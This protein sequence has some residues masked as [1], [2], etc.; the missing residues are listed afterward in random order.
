MQQKEEFKRLMQGGGPKSQASITSI[1]S[2]MK[3]AD[4]QSESQGIMAD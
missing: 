4:L 1:T 2:E 3:I